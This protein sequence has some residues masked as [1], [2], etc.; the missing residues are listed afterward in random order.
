VGAIAYENFS[1]ATWSTMMRASIRLHHGFGERS[2]LQTRRSF[3]ED[4]QTQHEG[5]LGAIGI[6]SSSNL[7]ILVEGQTVVVQ[8]SCRTLVEGP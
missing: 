5:S 6:D 4:G 7:P 3:S 1:Y 2:E 8:A